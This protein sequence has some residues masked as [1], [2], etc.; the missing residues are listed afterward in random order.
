MTSMDHIK[1]ARRATDE[2]MGLIEHAIIIGDLRDAYRLPIRERL[3]KCRVALYHI[4]QD[5]AASTGSL[6]EI[7]GP[8]SKAP[9]TCALPDDSATGVSPSSQPKC[10]SERQPA[11]EDRR[12]AKQPNGTDPTSGKRTHLGV[13]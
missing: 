9:R 4:H 6:T 11:L 7:E 10:T 12:G 1:E 13:P 5:M 2:A 8:P 3:Q